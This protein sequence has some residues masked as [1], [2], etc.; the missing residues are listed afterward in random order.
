[1]R[2]RL[3]PCLLAAVAATAV[4][5][6]TPWALRHDDPDGTPPSLAFLQSQPTGDMGIVFVLLPGGTLPAYRIDE[7]QAGAKKRQSVRL[8]PFFLAST[9]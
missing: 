2:S 1:M 6:S 4:A 9:R 3:R 5:C 8:D 7:D